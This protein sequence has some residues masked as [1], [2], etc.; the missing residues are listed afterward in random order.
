MSVCP[1]CGTTYPPRVRICTLDGTVLEEDGATSAETTDTGTLL[2]RKYR[3][4]APLGRGGMGAV[5]RATHVMLGKTVAVK[6]IK[7]DL[8]GSPDMVR[9]FQREARAATSLNHPNIVSVYDLGQAG[10]GTLYIAM[11]LVEGRSLKEE[12]TA[13]GPMQPGRIASLLTQVASAL[14][15][16][17]RHGIVH[18]DLKPQNL[19]ISRA[20]DGTEVV[21]LLDFGIA[22]THE[23]GATQLTQTGFA[24]G[25]PQY[26]APEQA[27]GKAVDGRTDLYAL[28]VILY[29]MLTGEVPFND[30][31]TPAVLVKHLSELPEPPSRRKAGLSISPLLE[32]AALK[33]LEKDPAN[34][35]QTAEEFIAAIAPVREQHP[36]V[37]GSAA[38]IV[39]PPDPAA[40]AGQTS[41]PTAQTPPR[42][43]ASPPAGAP[44]APQIPAPPPVPATSAQAPIAEA[45]APV[46][47]D[48][49]PTS[50]VAPAP[51]IA[52]GAPAPKR[53]AGRGVVVAL[54]V[55]A[56]VVVFLGAAAGLLLYRFGFI[57]GGGETAEAIDVPH[58]SPAMASDS[59]QPADSSSSS[60]AP[61][62]N[63]G[64]AD[65]NAAASTA[66]PTGPADPDPVAGGSPAPSARA[67]PP[68]VP[69]AAGDPPQA[70]ARSAARSNAV[71]PARTREEPPNREAAASAAPAL[72]AVPATYV[73]CTGA[74]EVCGALRT[75][76]VEALQ[77][78]GVSVTRRADAA[79]MV[80]TATAQPGETQAEQQFGTNFVVQ[81]VTI[82]VS[83]ESPRLAGAEVPMPAPRT[84]T[85]DTRFGRDRIGD[86]ARLV[87]GEV[88]DRVMQFWRKS[89]LKQ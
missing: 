76:I 32:H 8:V 5:Y 61:T 25:T 24:L 73:E 80:L 49:R 57:G 42:A 78:D 16:A 40:V 86:N 84:F 17:H 58:A 74:P 77:R 82:D 33:C 38:T 68:S 47:A 31:S 34:R 72:P 23:E 36:A 83:A 81:S 85:Y 56:I 13:S 18:R 54:A 87:A 52:P 12:V 43:V 70:A 59:T 65:A 48:T 75:A 41:A 71:A 26:M 37:D 60:E 29:E 62:A 14:G 28:G 44:A 3:L 19:M 63:D 46:S 10:D 66:A 2:D 4:D 21:K 51:A 39:V 35:F 22:K 79:D 55:A 20:E 89:A 15:V 30:P 27:A 53:F 88:A 7:A 9:R 6:L 11:E 1:K 45:P 69:A 50:P 67:A 64:A